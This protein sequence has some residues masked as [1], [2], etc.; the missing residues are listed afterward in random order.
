MHQESF[1]DLKRSAINYAVSNEP[2]TW[3][4]E[5]KR[6]VERCL[7][8]E[9]SNHCLGQQKEMAK[10]LGIDRN[11]LRDKLRQHG[12]LADVRETAKA[13]R[14]KIAHIGRLIDAGYSGSQ[15]QEATGLSLQELSRLGGGL[16]ESRLNKLR[17]NNNKK[18]D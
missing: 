4:K 11:S 16:R 10:L 1:A 6:V 2:G 14:T 9:A 7:L 5:T 13:A 12:I 3:M 8:L 17:K 18:V 15:I